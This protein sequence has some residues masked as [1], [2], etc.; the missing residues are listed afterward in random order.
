MGDFG[1]WYSAGKRSRRDF[2]DIDPYRTGY[3]TSIAGLL[4]VGIG[5]G[6]RSAGVGRKD[7]ESIGASDLARPRLAYD[8]G[9]GLSPN[10]GISTASGLGLRLSGAAG[11]RTLGGTG[12]GALDD[13]ALT[14][15]LAAYDAGLC[16]RP[17]VLGLSA[18]ALKSENVRWTEDILHE[19]ES[20]T[21]FVDGLPADCSRR[22]AAHIFRPFM[23]FKTVRVVHK[24]VKRLL[25]E[26]DARK[27]VLGYVDFTDSKCAATAMQALE[28]YKF[29]ENDPDSS[30][31]KFSFARPLGVEATGSR[32]RSTVHDRNRS[33]VR[34]RDSRR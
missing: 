4:D 3:G 25:K 22:E 6:D 21:L 27:L 14:A 1:S 11:F 7:Y 23:G 13:P 2:E 32:D 29:D 8:G 12:I 30:T 20:P 16:G 9:G 18:A 19:D 17:P 28:G 26:P 34:A 33:P 5:Y 31:L 10:L 15:C 24:F